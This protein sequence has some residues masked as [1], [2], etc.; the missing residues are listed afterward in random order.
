M[1]IN[2]KKIGAIVL[3]V[4]KPI[5]VGIVVQKVAKVPIVRDLATAVA[6]EVLK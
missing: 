5:V 1:K 6:R 2:L 3:K 4:A